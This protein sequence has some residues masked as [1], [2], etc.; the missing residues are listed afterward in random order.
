MPK[1][2]KSVE[3]TELS[4]VEFAQLCDTYVSE[5][6]VQKDSSTRQGEA[7]KKLQEYVIKHGAKTEKGFS[8]QYNL[9]GKC[10]SVTYNDVFSVSVS[11]TALTLLDNYLES[12][13]VTQETYDALSETYKIFRE[14]RLEQLHVEGKISSEMVQ[15]FYNESKSSR[16]NI[17]VKDLKE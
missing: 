7:K 8:Q 3:N 4:V 15:S 5:R 13:Q 6:D 12:N 11:P 10:Y 17:T 1:V 16:I 9:D 14:D 2:P